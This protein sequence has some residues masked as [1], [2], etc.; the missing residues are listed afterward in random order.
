[1]T[2]WLLSVGKPALVASASTVGALWTQLNHFSELL[3][4]NNLQEELSGNYT[5]PV[6]KSNAG[7]RQVKQ[8]K[9]LPF[10]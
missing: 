5:I 3:L 8:V 6:E 9:E 1:V 4:K 2:T 10:V 7:R